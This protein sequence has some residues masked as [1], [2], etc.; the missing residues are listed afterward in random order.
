MSVSPLHTV[1]PA[2]IGGTEV[3]CLFDTGATAS[4]TSLANFTAWQHQE[5][6]KVGALVPGRYTAVQ[7]GAGHVA[8]ICGQVAIPR[9]RL[10][11]PGIVTSV[12][13]VNVLDGTLP[14]GVD[15]ILG[16][17]WLTAEHVTI[18]YATARCTVGTVKRASFHLQQSATEPL[19]AGSHCPQAQGV[20]PQG[21]SLSTAEA[22][23]PS[24]VTT[25]GVGTDN[26]GLLHCAGVRSRHTH[27]DSLPDPE[28]PP[29]LASLT[30][31]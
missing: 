17:D 9:L 12:P 4:F 26:P 10:G 16:Q 11:K 3:R 21:R 29:W 23:Q 28:P 8:R 22:L 13:Q 1:F 24:S 5:G 25:T 6:H 31:V 30:A 2:L 20:A 27:P 14:E 19:S 7:T 18:D 15:L